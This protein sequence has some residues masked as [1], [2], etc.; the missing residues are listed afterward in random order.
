MDND[1]ATIDNGQW[2]GHNWQWTMIR[3]QLSLTIM[4][5][6]FDMLRTFLLTFPMLF[7]FTTCT[8][9]YNFRVF[10]KSSLTSFPN[11]LLGISGRTMILLIF[12]PFRLSPVTNATI[13][14]N[15]SFQKT[16]TFWTYCWTNVK[17]EKIM[18]EF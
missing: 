16:N 8:F 3:P 18:N 11:G 5:L 12:W 14:L 7:T 17:T 9:L 2:W 4:K 1:K 15:S 10:L 6:K 13:S